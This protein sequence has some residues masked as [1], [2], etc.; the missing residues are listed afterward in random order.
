MVKCFLFVIESNIQLTNI[1]SSRRSDQP[2]RLYKLPRM[3]LYSIV[4]TRCTVWISG[5]RCTCPGSSSLYVRAPE[6]RWH[7]DVPECQHGTRRTSASISVNTTLNKTMRLPSLRLPSPF[8]T[9]SNSISWRFYPRLLK[10]ELEPYPRATSTRRLSHAKRV[11][12][13]AEDSPCLYLANKTCPL[14]GDY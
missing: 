11:F 7:N 14:F 13:T 9:R 8:L 3:L 6:G 12:G 5:V 10:H 1:G 4:P 2:L